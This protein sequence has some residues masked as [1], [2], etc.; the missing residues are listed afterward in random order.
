MKSVL[1]AIHHREIAGQC[2]QPAFVNVAADELLNGLFT[3]KGADAP[4]E[5]TKREGLVAKLTSKMQA[6]YRL[7]TKDKDGGAEVS[8]LYPSLPIV[9]HEYL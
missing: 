2:A 1:N 9:S 5:F 7:D 3:A 8:L 6:W 4:P